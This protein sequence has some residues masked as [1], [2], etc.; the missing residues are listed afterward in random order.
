[1]RCASAFAASRSTRRGGSSSS[2]PTETI[3]WIEHK[4]DC[5]DTR[6]TTHTR[7]TPRTAA[8]REIPWFHWVLF[9][10]PVL[11]DRRWSGD[12][13]VGGWRFVV[14]SLISQLNP[15]SIIGAVSTVRSDGWLPARQRMTREQ[16]CHCLLELDRKTARTTDWKERDDN[17]KRT[18]GA[19][20]TT[21]VTNE[22]RLEMPFS[23]RKAGFQV[24]KL[25]F[26]SV[27]RDVD[28]VSW[29]WKWQ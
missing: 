2:I 19:N 15:A 10:D 11:T 27:A 16:E 6:N 4:T 22:E 9:D 14:I 5:H 20:R 29:V 18:S 13:S 7:S 28:V 24:S 25:Y 3:Q 12:T 23:A 17:S 1:M 8:P 26:T 21:T